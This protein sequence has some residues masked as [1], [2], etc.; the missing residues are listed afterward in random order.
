MTEAGCAL[1]G[2]HSVS[3]EELKFGYAV[4]GTV[5]P[6]RFITNAG[7]RPGDGLVLTK[8]LGTGVIATALKRGMAREDD[9]RASIAS[10]LELNRAACKRMLAFTVHAC[11][12]V[13]GF[14]LIGHAREM[15]AASGVT[16]EIDTAA[17]PLLPGA[18]EYARAGAI[19]GGLKNNREYNGCH[20]E[21]NGE[22]R[23]VLYDPQTSGGLLIAL[24]REEAA[25]FGAP[26]IGRVME[27]QARPIRLV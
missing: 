13:T 2:G 27:R 3:D 12:D 15:A 22:V 6:Q 8:P 7:A 9:V 10:M 18:E 5:H 19:A 1:L 11:T 20:V 24:P 25:R 14:G 23:D 4:T 17:V 26:V 21:A 16:L